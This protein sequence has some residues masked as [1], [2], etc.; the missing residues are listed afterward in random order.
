MS[1]LFGGVLLLGADLVAQHLLPTA[2]PV[3]VVTVSVGGA[4]L[5]LMI[6]LEIRRRA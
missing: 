1:A 5:V 3:G 2:L 4:Y 6:V